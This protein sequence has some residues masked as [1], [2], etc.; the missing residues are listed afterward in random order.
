M[1]ASFYD[2]VKAHVPRLQFRLILDIW[3]HTLLNCL[4]FILVLATCVRNVY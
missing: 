1:K 3:T 4:E 2:K